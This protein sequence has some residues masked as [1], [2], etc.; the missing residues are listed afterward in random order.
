MWLEVFGTPSDRPG[1]GWAH[2]DVH[3]STE[4]LACKRAAIMAHASQVSP[5]ID[6]D[7][8][9]FRAPPEV[10]D[11]WLQPVERFYL[12]PSVPAERVAFGTSGHRG[13]SFDGTFN[14]ARLENATLAALRAPAA[15]QNSTRCAPWARE[16]RVSAEF[17]KATSTAPNSL[18]DAERP[19]RRRE[20]N[21]TSG[22]G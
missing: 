2:L 8:E 11:L 19:C 7:P 4:E 17:S 18:R 22:A 5:L 15:G 10:L 12:D 21:A 20:P 9:G 3:L 13:T 1:A 16:I 6:D 14:E